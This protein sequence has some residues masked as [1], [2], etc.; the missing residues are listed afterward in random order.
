MNQIGRYQR[1]TIEVKR[2]AGMGK[3]VGNS[4]GFSVRAGIGIVVENRM[5]I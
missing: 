3:Q 4:I 5:V 2:F 1:R